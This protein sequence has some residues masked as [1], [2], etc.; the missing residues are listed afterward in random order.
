MKLTPK[1]KQLIINEYTEF[2][3]SMYAGKSLEERQELGQFFT[4]PEITITMI[5]QYDSFDE[6]DTLLDPCMGA[7]GLLTACIVAGLVKPDNVFGIELDWDIYNI[8]KARLI[9]LG[10]PKNRFYEKAPYD[11]TGSK[12]DIEKAKLNYFNKSALATR[13][14]EK[15]KHFFCGNALN[16]NSYKFTEE[17]IPTEAVVELGNGIVSFNWNDLK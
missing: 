4:P 11:T 7:G 15:G 8:A 1:Q 14:P 17:E 13:R 16:K 5:E 2:E 12:D 10:V 3:T 6:N 9:K